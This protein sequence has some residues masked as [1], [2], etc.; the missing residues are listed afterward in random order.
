MQTARQ[1][2]AEYA[3]GEDRPLSG[4]SALLAAYGVTAAGLLAALR[5]AGKPLPERIAA[6][7]LLLIAVATHKISR[8]VAKSPVAS[9]L[10]APFSRYG[11][12]TGDAELTDEPRG[13]GVR[14][15][16]GE[17]VTCPFCLGQWVS[18]GLTFGLVVAPRVTRLTAS[19]FAAHAGSDM[20]QFVYAA[21]DRAAEKVD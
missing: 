17:L 21:L 3:H 13:D 2:G 9:P 11:E 6:S 1:Q 20:L 8:L 14:H 7:D 4:Y 15:A 18:T 19:V 12:L 16:L 10:R 5:A